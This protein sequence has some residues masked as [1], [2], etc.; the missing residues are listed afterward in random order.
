LSSHS[1]SRN[2]KIKIPYKNCS[3]V[4]RIILGPKRQEV[5]GRWRKL[6]N[7]EFHNLYFSADVVRAI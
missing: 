4:L 3:R 2:V 5:P 1:I 6:H 7:E